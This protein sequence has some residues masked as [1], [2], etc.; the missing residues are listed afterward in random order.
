MRVSIRWFTLLSFVSAFAMAV[1]VCGCRTQNLKI[2]L[3]SKNRVLPNPQ[4]RRVEVRVVETNR[5]VE[6]TQ[7]LV[8]KMPFRT[9]IVSGQHPTC[10]NLKEIT[11]VAYPW[12]IRENELSLLFTPSGKFVGIEDPDN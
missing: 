1:I 5:V 3:K 10:P 11:I 12:D 4:L 8:P 2:E 7:T 6:L 9:V